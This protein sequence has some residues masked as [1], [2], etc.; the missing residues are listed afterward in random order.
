MLIQVEINL[1][2]NNILLSQLAI[3]RYAKGASARCNFP[4]ALS[5]FALST[6]AKSATPTTTAFILPRYSNWQSKH[7]C[8]IYVSVCGC[9]FMCVFVGLQTI[10]IRFGI[11][12]LLCCPGIGAKPK[13]SSLLVVCNSQRSKNREHIHTYTPAYKDTHLHTT[14]SF[15]HKHCP[16]HSPNQIGATRRGYFIAGTIRLSRDTEIIASWG[17][18]ER[19]RKRYRSVL[20]CVFEHHVC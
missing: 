15:M 17:A 20:H 13:L 10:E 8:F 4:T 6:L 16:R 3:V 18:E 2:L 9:V 12:E 11:S 7:F 5:T 1:N 19:R 14:H